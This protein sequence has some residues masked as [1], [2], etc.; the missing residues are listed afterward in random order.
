MSVFATGQ[1]SAYH[2][3]SNNVTQRR[4]H[5]DILPHQIIRADWC[6]FVRT[7]LPLASILLSYDPYPT[8]LLLG[9]I[10]RR[11]L[12]DHKLEP[13]HRAQSFFK[14]IPSLD[15][16]EHILIVHGLSHQRRVI[17]CCVKVG[18]LSEVREDYLNISLVTW[19]KGRDG[20]GVGVDAA[21][22]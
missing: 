17:G 22:L 4:R 20:T 21:S 1:V 8:V 13:L 2:P 16:I 18:R 10:L 19:S 5:I 12:R 6:H 14:C 11:I 15:D 9:I 3:T 7:T